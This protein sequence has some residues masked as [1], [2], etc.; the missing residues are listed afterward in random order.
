MS[1]TVVKLFSRASIGAVWRKAV[2]L[3][4]GL[5]KTINSK[6][7]RV[8]WGA[9]REHHREQAAYW[10]PVSTFSQAWALETLDTIIMGE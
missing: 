6:V 1:T 7:P 10:G 2:K 9:L 3:V 4:T 5:G 8:S